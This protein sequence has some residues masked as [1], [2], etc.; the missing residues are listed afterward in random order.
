[1]LQVVVRFKDNANDLRLKKICDYFKLTNKRVADSYLPR[2]LRAEQLFFYHPVFNPYTEK[3]TH[4]TAPEMVGETS[5][6]LSG[7]L[8]TEV[9]LHKLGAEAAEIL[10]L[11]RKD[12]ASSCNT[13]MSSDDSSVTDVFVMGIRDVCRGCYSI[14]D[15]QEI[16]PRYPW[17][18][19]GGRSSGNSS[20][21]YMR[22]TLVH[23]LGMS[24]QNKSTSNRAH[25]YSGS[26]SHTARSSGSATTSSNGGGMNMN[27]ISSF[28]LSKHNSAHR[29]GPTHKAYSAPSSSAVPSVR[30][31]EPVKPLV[32]GKTSSGYFLQS[33]LSQQHAVQPQ[34]VTQHTHSSHSSS[35]HSRG[36]IFESFE[37]LTASAST[38]TSSSVLTTVP[39]ELH[40]V[41]DLCEDSSLDDVASLPQPAS[42]VSSAHSAHNHAETAAV[43]GG[44]HEEPMSVYDVMDSPLVVKSSAPLVTCSTGEV[45]SSAMM[46]ENDVVDLTASPAPM[47]KQARL[48]L[49]GFRCGAPGAGDADHDNAMSPSKLQLLLSP[50]T[51]LHHHQ[52]RDG[53]GITH[54]LP[55][56]QGPT[57][58][59]KKSR[60]HTEAESPSLTHS[61]EAYALSDNGSSPVLSGSTSGSKPAQPAVRR[62]TLGA[63]P[64]VPL[65]IP[66][67][68]SATVHPA[69]TNVSTSAT[70]AFSSGTTG[71]KRKNSFAAVPVPRKKVTKTQATGTIMVASIKSFFSAV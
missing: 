68:P 23:A 54:P 45:L 6:T 30:A 40:M 46:V 25:T 47:R 13:S 12:G 38:S 41:Y 66:R 24:T 58:T 31:T 44:G 20:G 7:P 70:G 43:V 42:C 49:Q 17:E 37:L 69:A 64:F 2:I 15:H 39:E 48:D 18:I 55:L 60:L 50:S 63:A 26:S 33:K 52:D 1:M 35:I 61:L 32:V 59:T 4:F 27:A 65:H 5:T 21:W 71:E 51:D 28:M 8:I 3:I 34:V 29:P 10:S 36:H 16:E 56:Q 57:A 62:K 9:E 19:D 11:S 14:K 22:R 53:N 67:A